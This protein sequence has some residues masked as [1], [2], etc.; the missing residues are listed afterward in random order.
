MI[1]AD[2]EKGRKKA[3]AARAHAEGGLRRHLQGMNGLPV[4]I[5]LLDPPLH[6]F[7]P[8]DGAGRARWPARWHPP[9]RSSAVESCTRQTRCSASAAAGC[10]SPSP[11][12][13]HAG[14][15]H[16]RGRHR[17]EEEGQDVLPEIMIPLVGTV[18]ELAFLKKRAVAVAEEVFKKAGTR[19]SS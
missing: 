4:T 12:S 7:L 2:D 5:R 18:E 10:G 17:G 9:R 19:S 11:R 3:L 13:R 16:H 14:A 8:H 6:E 15:G 1:L